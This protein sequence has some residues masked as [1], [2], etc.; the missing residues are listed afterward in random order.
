MFYKF[1]NSILNYLAYIYINIV[2]IFNYFSNAK[3]INDESWWLPYL[4]EIQWYH[5]D[6]HLQS[7]LAVPAL[8]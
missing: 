5:L 8:K 6:P 7:D 4:L 1:R 2:L 3:L